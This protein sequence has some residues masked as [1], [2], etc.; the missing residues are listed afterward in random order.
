MSIIDDLLDVKVLRVRSSWGLLSD[1][2]KQKR[3]K[4]QGTI[5]R[6]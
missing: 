5:K 4:K 6:K 1:I 2:K 3:E